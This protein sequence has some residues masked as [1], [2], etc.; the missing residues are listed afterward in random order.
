MIYTMKVLFIANIT[1]LFAWETTKENVF[2]ISLGINKGILI[3]KEASLDK[4][5]ALTK[6]QCIK[7]IKIGI[8]GISLLLVF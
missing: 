6:A 5:L 8:K 2:I 1:T 4:F 3:R 7:R